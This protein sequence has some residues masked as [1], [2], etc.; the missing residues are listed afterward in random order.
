MDNS[1]DPTRTSADL[2]ANRNAS[3]VKV[4]KLPTTFQKV[5]DYFV[6][7]DVKLVVRCNDPLYDKS[8]FTK[9]GIDHVEMVRLVCP[10]P[11]LR[12]S[13]L[14]VTSVISSSTKMDPIPL[15]SS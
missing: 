8:E 14:N 10:R 11:V 2:A 6:K 3:P 9:R 12:T 5:L 15:R 1:F 13:A 4:K 7:H